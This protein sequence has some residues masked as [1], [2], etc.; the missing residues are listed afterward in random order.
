MLYYA[1]K[2]GK[3][4]F[5]IEFSYQMSR[6]TRVFFS[7]HAKIMFDQNTVQLTA[8]IT[9][10][11]CT[12]LVTRQMS[13]TELQFSKYLENFKSQVFNFLPG[14]DTQTPLNDRMIQK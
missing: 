13:R 2:L 3:V 9:V 8:H 4:L 1:V 11:K 10:N 7:V 14:F 6:V 12:H 5:E